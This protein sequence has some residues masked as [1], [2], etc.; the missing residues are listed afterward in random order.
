MFYPKLYKL[1]VD[2]I[3]WMFE[4]IENYLF[5]LTLSIT[6]AIGI[7]A[8][9]LTALSL[10]FSYKTNIYSFIR[11]INNKSLIL[12]MNKQEAIKLFSE[13]ISKIYNSTDLT[14]DLLKEIEKDLKKSTHY[15]L[16]NNI[17]EN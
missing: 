8:F 6:I 9:I 14:D 13:L 10:W 7:I 3:I 15:Y 2:I 4:I 1:I 12:T 11:L 5:I 16:E 17:I